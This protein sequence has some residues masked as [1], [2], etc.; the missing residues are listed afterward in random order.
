MKNDLT[1][2]YTLTEKE[3]QSSYKSIV[4]WFFGLSGSGKSTLCNSIEQSLFQNNIKTV[5]LDGD[6]L[7]NG[8]NKDLDFSKEDRIENLRR[9]SEISKILNKSGLLTL[10]SF[11]TP[12]EKN[13]SLINSIIG[14]KNIFW[15]FVDTPIEECIKRDTK[16]LYKKA[17]KGEIKNFTGISSPFENPEY[18]DF[19]VENNKNIDDSTREITSRILSKIKIK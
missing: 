10:C 7:R 6:S 8:L 14:R 15:I 19:R 12:F 16:G 1:F 13:R 3:K 18:C 2:S 4:V 17:I 11:I 5:V 9:V